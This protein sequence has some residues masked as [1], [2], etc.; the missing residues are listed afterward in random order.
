VQKARSFYGRI[1]AAATAV[2]CWPSLVPGYLVD[3]GLLLHLYLSGVWLVMGV[4]T[5]LN[6]EIS[7]FDD[8]PDCFLIF[9]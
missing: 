3:D 5:K 7:S 6:F 9:Y 8:G 4:K 1:P 2:E